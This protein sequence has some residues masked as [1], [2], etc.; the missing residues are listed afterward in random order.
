VATG[1]VINR[2]QFTWQGTPART[3]A[4]SARAFGVILYITLFHW[5]MFAILELA[6]IILDPNSPYDDYGD[7]EVVP[8][9][10]TGLLLFIIVV[11]KILQWLYIGITAFV[12]WSLR[13]SVRAKYGIPG[14]SKEDCIWSCCC[15]CLV[16][17]QLLRHTTD[18]E[19]Y[20]SQLCSSTGLSKSAPMLV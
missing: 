9:P 19:V 1:Q 15:P 11:Y 20:P 5:F 6:I 8:K 18:Y 3:A 17:G 14:N 7:T 12:L 2:L 4:S 16:A 10:I 13:T